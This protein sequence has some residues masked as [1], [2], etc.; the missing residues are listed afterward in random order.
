[1]LNSSR[2]WS[3]FL[4]SLKN[5]RLYRQSFCVCPLPS[6]VPNQSTVENLANFPVHWSPVLNICWM[7]D[8][9]IRRWGCGSGRMA[10]KIKRYKVKGLHEVYKPCRYNWY[11]AVVRTT[12]VEKMIW[13]AGLFLSNRTSGM[14]QMMM[15]GVPMSSQPSQ[16][17][18]QLNIYYLQKQTMKEL[19]SSK[20]AFVLCSCFATK[21]CYW[22]VLGRC[23]IGLDHIS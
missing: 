9:N 11:F 2:R 20:W 21:S 8:M 3:Y 12:A 17:S 5:F 15:W 6:P 7:N 19:I 4:S 16:C 13:A 14:C 22:M 18:N 10:L 1:M 23:A